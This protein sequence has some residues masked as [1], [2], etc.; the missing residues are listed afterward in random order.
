MTGLTVLQVLG[1]SDGDL[2]VET[3]HCHSN[4]PGSTRGEHKALEQCVLAKFDS[5]PH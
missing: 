5:S 2:V 1:L 3:G 4:N